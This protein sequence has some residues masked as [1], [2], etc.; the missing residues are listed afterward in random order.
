MVAWNLVYSKYALKDAKKISAAGL[1]D[2]A[3][4][5]LEL[6]EI[7]PYQNPPPY[8]KLVGDL[9]G[10]YSCRINIQHRLVYEVFRKEKTVRILRMWTH[11]E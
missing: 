5:L 3:R 7:D 4:A 9:K 6:L 10:A 1:K 2:K 8:E 11:Y